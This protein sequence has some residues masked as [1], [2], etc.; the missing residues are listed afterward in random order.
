MF[1]AFKVR[2]PWAAA[3]IAF[4]DPFIGML[5]LGRAAVAFFYF[6]LE[7]A[8]FFLFFYLLPDAIYGPAPQ[9]LAGMVFLPIRLTGT[10]HA[11]LIAG[12]R[13]PGAAPQWYARWYVVV[14]AALCVP[15]VTSAAK[16]YL[17]EIVYVA[18]P[19]MAPTLNIGDSIAVW[20]PSRGDLKRGDIVLFDSP[21]LGGMVAMRIAG[22]PGDRVEIRDGALFVNGAGAAVSRVSPGIYA[23]TLPGGRRHLILGDGSRT[24]G[25]V[26]VAPA[27]HLLLLG[28]NR[29][30]D[31]YGY[32]MPSIVRTEDVIG[33]VVVK[34]HDGVGRA[35]VFRSVH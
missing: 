34:C 28:D 22:L 8:T 10:V 6:G 5:Y 33:K 17:F 29:Q 32:A 16:A 19:N 25:R 27:G 31:Y 2:R 1:E 30:A 20:K 15:V 12:Q 24:T 26:Y 9:S 11:F 18:H 21:V 7:L 35:Y 13:Q 3:A 23:E 4:I 14:L